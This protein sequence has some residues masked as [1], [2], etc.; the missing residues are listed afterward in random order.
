MEKLSQQIIE[1]M[2][3]LGMS[4]LEFGVLKRSFGSIEKVHNYLFKKLVS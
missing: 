1:M 3:E 2:S 4:A